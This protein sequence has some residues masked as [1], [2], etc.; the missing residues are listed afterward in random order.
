[1]RT[2]ALKNVIVNKTERRNNCRY[3]TLIRIAGSLSPYYGVIVVLSAVSLLL[4]LFT[5]GVTAASAAPSVFVQRHG[6]TVTVESY[7]KK[8]VLL[9]ILVQS[10]SRKNDKKQCRDRKRCASLR[11]QTFLSNNLI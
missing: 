4:I 1:M 8:C 9:F 7:A 10:Q 3:R 5:Y 11:I 2:K 6:R